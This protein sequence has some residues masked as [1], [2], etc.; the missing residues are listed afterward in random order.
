MNKNHYLS[1]NLMYH[2]TKLAILYSKAAT[3]KP[4]IISLKRR[5]TTFDAKLPSSALLRREPPRRMR[6]SWTRRFLPPKSDNLHPVE[7]G[8]PKI[9]PTWTKIIRRLCPRKTTEGKSLNR[10]MCTTLHCRDP[11]LNS[12]RIPPPT[13]PN[14]RH[15]R[16]KR[17]TSWIT[18]KSWISRC[19]RSKKKCCRI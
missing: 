16:P 10:T 4:I 9:F 7:W 19:S 13:H 3:I 17:G 12:T 11:R 5:I 1:S 15:C 2:K 14:R 8:K 18:W 6:M